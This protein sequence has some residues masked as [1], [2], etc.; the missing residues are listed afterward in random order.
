MNFF[1]KAAL[2]CLSIL[3]CAAIGLGA[4]SCAD[5]PT[6]SSSGNPTSSSTAPEQSSGNEPTAPAE[7]VYRISVENAGGYAFTGVTVSLLK[8]GETVA[9]KKTTDAGFAYFEEKDGVTPDNYD[10]AVEGYPE[11]YVLEETYK[12]AALAGQ[13]YTAVITPTGVLASEAPANK[14]YKLGDVMHDFSMVTSDGTTFN[15]SHVL[16]EKELVV[17]N[18][19]ATWC[20][21]CKSEFPAMHNAL[22]EYKDS[23]DCIAVSVSDDQSAVKSF[24]SQNGYGF[25]MAGVN[26][27]NDHFAVG[28]NVP[29]TYMVDRYGVIV[30]DH[31]GTMTEMRDWSVRFDKFLGEDY[32]PYI[33]KNSTDIGGGGGDDEQDKPDTVKPNVS[34]PSIKDVET[35]L[36]V[37]GDDFRFRF[38]EFGVKE[39]DDAYDEY[40]WP[41]IVAEDKDGKYLKASNQ[42]VLSSYSILY[43]DYNAKAGDVL[44]FDYK[45][46][47]EERYDILY[48]M[49]NGVPVVKLW[50]NNSKDWSTCYGYV[51]KDYEV[52]DAEIAFAFVK[53]GQNNYYE[54]IAYIRNL[55]VLTVDDIPA[56]AG[57]NAHVFRYAA[58]V[59][60]E[61]E[62]ATTQYK[63]YADVVLNEKDGYY[64]V[65]NENGP[66]LYAN[67]WYAS[68]W[69]E[70][71]AWMLTFNNYFAHDGFNYYGPFEEYAWAANQPTDFWGYTPVDEDLKELLDLMVKYVEAGQIWAGEY[72][73]KEWLERCCYNDHYGDEPYKDTMAGITFH[74]A[75][76]LQL[77]DNHISVPYAINPR[78]F[79]Y[80][81]TPEVSGIYRVYT[82]GSSNTFGFLFSENQEMLGSWD[83]KFF[84]E[85]WKDENGTTVY[86]ENFEFYWNFEAGKI[87]YI[88]YTTYGDQAAEYNSTI[89]YI[90]DSYTY[91]KPA[92]TSYSQNTATGE[93]FVANAPEYKYSDPNEGGDGYYHVV[94][95]DGTLG[96]ILYLDTKNPTY[97]LFTQY[98]IH[99]TIESL[100]VKD[101]TGEWTG[102]WKKEPHERPFYHN[103][104][105]Y[106]ETLDEYCFYAM[107]NSGELN[108]YIAVDQT[109]Y[110]TLIAITESKEYDGGANSW[111]LLCYYYETVRM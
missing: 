107:Q 45:I 33:F 63:H 36:G 106:T 37:S 12:T 80:K 22:L 95:E 79:K 101:A 52:G 75:I 46:G 88:L 77:G 54:D 8:D 40:N 73:D 65:G 31:L 85:S 11:G 10:I 1:K 41:W 86:D 68:L 84:V 102:E 53:D 23:V 94:N 57:A 21:P 111:L 43:A 56:D 35:T 26:S 104:V 5:I 32:Q 78:G 103:G 9:S 91:L 105:D 14:V 20:G 83:N 7:Y 19:W 100:K 39:G 90:G 64:H 51:F 58:N 2:V 66:L 4:A 47:S 71:S 61:D 96:S 48:L 98:S 109:L 89:E 108:G 72:H 34:A 30:F 74:A 38:Q 62:N 97:F 29:H 92:A 59:L 67:L 17:I 13:E 25:N 44:A 110:E 70:T 6:S 60:N 87:Y 69:N 55:R 28:L 15:L 81:F 99:A 3:T 18:F 27:F 42:A 93:I 50:G 76:E 24:K 82:T 16:A 49:V